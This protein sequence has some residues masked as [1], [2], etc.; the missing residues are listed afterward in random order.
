MNKETIKKFIEWLE[1]SG[2]E[3]IEAHRQY[4]LG[5]MKSISSD[6]RSDVRLSLRLID[7]EILARIELKRL[8]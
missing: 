2:D 8:G 1:N 6:G 4:I 3:E 5:K 7:E